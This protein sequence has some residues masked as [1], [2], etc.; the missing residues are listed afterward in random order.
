MG[1]QPTKGKKTEMSHAPGVQADSTGERRGAAVSFATKEEAI[2]YIVSLAPRGTSLLGRALTPEEIDLIAPAPIAC[3]PWLDGASIS[4]A[5]ARGV[6]SRNGLDDR[7]AAMRSQHAHA[8]RLR[9]Q[10][11]AIRVREEAERERLRQ[12]LQRAG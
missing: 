11:T 12:F 4:A 8:A 9:A 1:C 2:A 7:T 3:A 5:N 10:A 6:V